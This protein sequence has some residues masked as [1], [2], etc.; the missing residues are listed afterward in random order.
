[1]SE[2]NSN[3][4]SEEVDLG[5]LFRKIG[6]FF[7]KCVVILFN[8]IEFYLKFKYILLL[9]IAIGIAYGIYQKR[10]SEHVLINEAIVIPNFESVDYL[11]DKIDALNKKVIAEDTLFLNPIFG[12]NAFRLKEIEID[13]IDDLYNNIAKTRERVELFDI[14][15]ASKEAD[16]FLNYFSITKTYKHHRIT[17]KILGVDHS[18][19]IVQNL[20]NYL[21]DN[22]HYKDYGTIYREH[23]DFM[24]DFNEKMLEQID[25]ILSKEN[26]DNKSSHSFGLAIDE[27]NYIPEL[28]DR[29]RQI[30]EY[31]LN[32]KKERADYDSPIKLVKVDYNLI[33]TERLNVPPLI[34]YPILFILLFSSIF[35][36]KH[37][38]LKLK[39][40]SLEDKSA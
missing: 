26:L 28:I 36:I 16:V 37:V 39:L 22:Q 29:K 6:I 17:F 13:H 23:N 38:Y 4:S 12:K 1:M 11:Y 2:K 5:Y 21:N 40:I 34:K 8:V 14:L 31:L 15:S 32:L 35:F 30:S 20:I 10:N 9:L 3:L 24:I 33:D 7:K 25:T 27:K 19:K 18:E